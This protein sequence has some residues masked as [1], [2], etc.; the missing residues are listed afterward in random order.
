[1]LD[2]TLNDTNAVKRIL[3]EVGLMRPR[4]SRTESCTS[5]RC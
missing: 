5:R 3:S 1:M 4:R 2:V